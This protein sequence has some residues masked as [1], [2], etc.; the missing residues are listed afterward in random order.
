MIF[1]M[2][3][4]N[5]E[6]VCERVRRKL[7]MENGVY[8]EPNGIGGGLALWWTDAVEVVVHRRE[9]NFIDTT[10]NQKDGSG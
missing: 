1:L 2:E 5:N 9:T 7:R 8:V 3:T 10:V 6:G 4:K